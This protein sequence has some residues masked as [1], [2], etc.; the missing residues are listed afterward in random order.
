MRVGLNIPWFECGHDFGRRP[1]PWNGPG[2]RPKRDYRGWA[3][4]LARL[5]DE[6]GI[7]TFRMWLFG[8][9]VNYPDGRN[10][11]QWLAPITRP[12]IHNLQSPL[13]VPIRRALVSLSGTPDE[14]LRLR[15]PELPA[16]EP[17]FLEDFDEWL[18]ALAHHGLRLI[19]VLL[20]FEF[21]H[22]VEWQL[23]GV[24]SGGR[25]ALVFGNALLD[26]SPLGQ[27]PS[28]EASGASSYGAAIYREAI[29]RFHEAT[30]APLL[31]ISKQHAKAIAA[32][33]LC[34]EPDWSVEGGPIH[35][36]LRDT[37]NGEPLPW[38]RMP[39]QRIPFQLMPKTVPAEAMS[40]WLLDGVERIVNAG[41]AATIGF[42]MADPGWLSPALRSRLIEL[43][44]QG[45]YQHQV[46]H[47]PSL[48]EPWRLRPHR[49][50][51]IQPC[52]VGE[53]ATIQGHPL[54][55]HIAWWRERLGDLHRARSRDS[56]LRRRLEIVEDLGYPTAL[57]WSLHSRD[58]ATDFG[59]DVRS[60]ICAYKGDT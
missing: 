4:E 25:S 42:K 26:H 16:L 17:A 8:G 5:R 34:N 53:M 18:G 14:H 6:T 57:L 20:S 27:S 3:D 15:G 43:A 2:G 19:P 55:L 33:E 59:P 10:P 44:G 54:G 32:F 23:G 60:Q 56:Y 38:Y 22:P 35:L 29:A 58:I 46:H 41:I 7:D 12:A 28:P 47:Y 30:L 11:L 39:L 31:A 13:P 45:Q 9:G 49:E 37:R 48:Y 1:P 40:A 21:F 50:L 24:P 52:M 36:R 51:P